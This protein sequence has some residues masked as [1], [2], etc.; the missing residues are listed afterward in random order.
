MFTISLDN[1]YLMTLKRLLPTLYEVV[2]MVTR[3]SERENEKSERLESTDD[4]ILTVIPRDTM[5]RQERYI[6]F[7][8]TAIEG[9]S[10]ETKEVAK[11]LDEEN[12]FEIIDMDNHVVD[13]RYGGDINAGTADFMIKQKQS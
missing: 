7:Y 9:V 1:D 10:A 5:T 3:L 4:R 12:E 8:N 6:L 13:Y 11:N 2:D